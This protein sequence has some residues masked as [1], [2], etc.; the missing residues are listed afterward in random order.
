MNIEGNQPKTYFPTSWLRNKSAS[1]GTWE[2]LAACNILLWDVGAMYPPCKHHYENVQKNNQNQTNNFADNWFDLGAS[3]EPGSGTKCWADAMMIFIANI[4]GDPFS[5]SVSQLQWVCENVKR[6]W[7]T[8]VRQSTFLDPVQRG[9]EMDSSWNY[10][11]D[12]YSSEPRCILPSRPS[13]I[14]MHRRAQRHIWLQ[15]KTPDLRT[16][17]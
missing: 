4:I 17:T 9:P 1:H 3:V 2:A 12:M 15:G 8:E 16:S 11:Q 10:R 6:Y 14:Q 5:H 13:Q 7:F